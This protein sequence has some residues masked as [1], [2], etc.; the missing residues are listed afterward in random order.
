MAAVY[1]RN[2]EK[3]VFAFR[4]AESQ[5]IAYLI[6]LF[7][8]YLSGLERLPNLVAQH[9][10]IPSLLPAGDRFVFCF[11]EQELSVG[12]FWIAHV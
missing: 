11:G 9:I 1:V 10:L 8:C 4:P 5:I 6:R 3:G 12:G 7:R 2:D